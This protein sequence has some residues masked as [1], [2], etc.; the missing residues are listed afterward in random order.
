MTIAVEKRSLIVL[1]STT[2]VNWNVSLTIASDANNVTVNVTLNVYD[3]GG[4]IL[5][6]NNVVA[7]NI[8]TSN[9]IPFNLPGP[10]SPDEAGIYVFVASAR[11]LEENST[12]FMRRANVSLVVHGR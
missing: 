8:I 4:G 12:I 3:F 11:M 1:N 6:N 2:N 10:I 9:M 7:S 5:K